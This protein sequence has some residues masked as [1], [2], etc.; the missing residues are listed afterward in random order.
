MLNS[1]NGF[2][3]GVPFNI[4]DEVSYIGTTRLFISELSGT[5][6]IDAL[7]GLTRGE[8]I[9]EETRGKIL[10]LG[11]QSIYGR[12]YRVRFYAGVGGEINILENQLQLYPNITP[13]DLPNR[14]GAQP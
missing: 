8:Y 2:S 12:T 6:L 5:V 14:C 4:D 13:I 9:T 11:P 10:G 7:R 3:V 1:V